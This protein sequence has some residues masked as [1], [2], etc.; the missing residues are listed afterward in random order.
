M[1]SFSKTRDF[2]ACGLGADRMADTANPFRKNEA[3]QARVTRC[4]RI[5]ALDGPEL[6]VLHERLPNRAKVAM[7]PALLAVVAAQRPRA[8]AVALFGMS[9]DVLDLTEGL[10]RIG[11]RG[12]VLALAPPLP[13][14]KLVQRELASQA[15]G[16]RLRL[17]TVAA[18]ARQD[19]F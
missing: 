12:L 7:M 10:A 18:L 16:L 2:T 15:P 5:L 13:N 17:V 19:P 6:A 1:V 4:R 3:P 8:V 11:Y 9:H 14:R